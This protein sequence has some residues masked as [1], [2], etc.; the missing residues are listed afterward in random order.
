VLAAYASA[1]ADE[2]LDATLAV[3]VATY[4]PDD[5]LVKVDI[6]SMAHS[7]ESRSPMVDHAFMEFVASIPAGLK[8]RGAT[9]KY[10]LRRAVRPL[11]P[12]AVIDRPKMGFGVPIGDWLRGSLREL[13]YDTLLGRQSVERRL[14]RPQAV[15]TMLDEHTTGAAD[16]D[17]HIWGLLI[18]EL[19]FRRFIDERGRP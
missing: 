19:W 17:A 4:L 11:L 2:M 3:D 8:L 15:K 18:L 1:D 13:A 10:I 5:L 14:F 6:A 16:W 12:K 9:R 7:L